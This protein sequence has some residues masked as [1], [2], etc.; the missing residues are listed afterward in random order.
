M[1]NARAG[2]Q[3]RP[4]LELV[5]P[6]ALLTAAADS[7]CAWAWLSSINLYTWTGFQALCIPFCLALISISIYASGM[8]TNDIFDY[9]EDLLDRPSRPLPSQRVTASTAW[10]LALFLQGFAL[11]ISFILGK[12]INAQNMVLSAVVGSTIIATYLYN[13]SFKSTVLAP[14]FMGLCRFGNFWIGA[15]LIYVNTANLNDFA[16]PALLDSPLYFSLGTCLY[17]MSLTALSRHE[18]NGG[19]WAMLWG[20][21][22]IIASLHPLLW[23]NMKYISAWPIPSGFI[24][25]LVAIWLLSK[26]L[27]MFKSTGEASQVQQAVSAGIRGVAL[28]N[29]VLCVGFGQWVF[30]GILFTMTLAAGKVARWFY[31]T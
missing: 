27:P 12:L 31:A 9:E 8:M 18:V 15:S 28:T 11:S 20:A 23:I 2:G 7:L 30:A 24:N 10:Y 13:Y 21:I 1:S 19:K 3:L 14:I 6:P 29:I 17:V 5:R 26:C 25:L 4:F 16:Q 22:L